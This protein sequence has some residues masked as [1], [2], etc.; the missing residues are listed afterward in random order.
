MEEFE[1]GGKYDLAHCFVSTFKYVLTERGARAHLRHVAKHLKK[2][3]IYLL[4]FHLSNYDG[5]KPPTERWKGRR[6]EVE[7]DCRIESQPPDPQTRLEAVNSRLK[8]REA[9]RRKVLETE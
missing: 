6:G 2:G 1:L 4:G 5:V 3:G 7:V 9:G 8:I